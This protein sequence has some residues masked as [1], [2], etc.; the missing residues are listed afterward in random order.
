[1]RREDDHIELRF[2]ESLGLAGI[3]TIKFSLPHVSAFSTDLGGKHKS[4]LSG[5]GVYTITVQ[6]QQIVTLHFETEKSLPIPEPITSWDAFVPKEKLAS[7]HA[8]DPT[9]KGHPPFG[10]GSQTF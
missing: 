9:V 4:A 10:G 5:S 7:L 1:V 2:A 3:A 6:P 8:Y